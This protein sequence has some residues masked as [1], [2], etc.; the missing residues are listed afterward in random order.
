M[1]ATIDPR[2]AKLRIDRARWWWMNHND[3][4]IYHGQLTT[5][6]RDEYIAGPGG[7]QTACTNGKHIIWQVEFVEKMDEPEARGVL[8]HEA[9]HPGLGHLW[10]LP[11]DEWANMACDAVI[12]HTITQMKGYGTEIKLPM[13]VKPIFP[14]KDC[15]DANGKLLPE[16]VLY[17][18]YKKKYPNGR[19]NGKGQCPGMGVGDFTKPADAKNGD[20]DGDG[21]GKDP[22]DA[23]GTGQPDNSLKDQWER[24]VIQA[25]QIAE[26]LGKGDMPANFQQVLE[27]LAAQ[28]LDWVSETMDF[29]RNSMSQ[30]N[31]WSRAAKRHSWQPVFYPRKK[32]NEIGKIA[33]VRDTSGSVSDNRTQSRF[34][35]LVTDCMREIGCSAIVI[36]CDADIQEEYHLVPGDECPL[37]AK[38]GGGTDHRPVWK[39]LKELIEEG[40]EIAGAVLLTDCYTS[41]PEDDGEWPTLTL[42]INN[43]KC[44]FG[45]TI[46]VH[47]YMG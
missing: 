5:G 4:R 28:P 18:V 3:S 25:A 14:D 41:W 24:R 12:N 36:D 23:K 29:A 1:T 2:K 8:V 22:K 45:R 44:P 35:A 47:D 46:K 19:G 27:R 40:Q 38:G 21:S 13:W 6:L 26:A 31:D 17:H 37:V 32:A 43:E 10:R 42:S 7:P 11:H 20:G 16:E 30:K 33:F 9:L 15:F 34:A 39:R